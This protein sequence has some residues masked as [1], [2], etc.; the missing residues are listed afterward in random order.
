MTIRLLS[1]VLCILC[2]LHVGF[3]QA[4][5]SSTV[6]AAPD[7]GRSVLSPVQPIL[8]LPSGSERVTTLGIALVFLVGIGLYYDRKRR[9]AD[10][11]AGLQ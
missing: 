4:A 2:G 8:N 6:V 1:V 9:Q 3:S 7:T 5:D 10:R 11:R